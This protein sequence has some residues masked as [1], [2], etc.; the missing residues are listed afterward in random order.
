MLLI[1]KATSFVPDQSLHGRTAA[2][3]RLNAIVRTSAESYR[4]LLPGHSRSIL[5]S[6]DNGP[7]STRS[8]SSVKR[9]NSNVVLVGQ[10]RTIT[11]LSFT[12]T[13]KSVSMGARRRW[14]IAA[15][16]WH[17]LLWLSS[18]GRGGIMAREVWRGT[19]YICH[20]PQ[21]S[22][23]HKDGTARERWHRRISELDPER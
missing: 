15:K 17:S 1:S 2:N 9:R 4:R 11:K 21:E 23:P 10:N 16:A 7:N 6:G 13:K 12:S 5:G 19:V 18:S 22:S 3:A 14:F 8:T 20:P